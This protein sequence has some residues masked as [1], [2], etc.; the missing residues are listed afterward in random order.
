MKKMIHGFMAA[1]FI[2]LFTAAGSTATFAG[3]WNQEGTRWRCTGDD[4][5]DLTSQ[6]LE[7]PGTGLWYHFDEN[8]Y[9]ETGWTQVNGESYYFDPSGAMLA[10]RMAPDEYY[11]GTDS[12]TPSTPADSDG[13]IASSALEAVSLVNAARA[14]HGCAGLTVSD[15]LMQAAAVRAE[16]I[17]DHF[18]HTRPNGS[19][20]YT[21]L[22]DAGIDFLIAGENIAYGQDTPQEVVDA[23][24]N[25]ESH[26]RNILNSEYTEIGTGCFVRDGVRYWVQIFRFN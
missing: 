18:S 22:D 20:S 7:E 14:Q 8:G 11:V 25:S 13:H 21:V 5:F 15:S 10:D 12:S 2:L 19:A 6:W 24:M 4:G 17:V 9:M 16:E 26:R 1:G 3:T 23:W